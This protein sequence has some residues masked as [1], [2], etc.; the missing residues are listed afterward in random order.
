MNS[1]LKNY[2]TDIP[3]SR[4]IP[5]IQEILAKSG[6]RGIAFEYDGTGNVESIFFRLQIENGK[7]LTFKL[8]ANPKAV[9]QMMFGNLQETRGTQERYEAGR[10]Q[11]ALN[12]AWR[13]MKD[14]LLV[15]FSL[16]QLNQA[17]AIQVF[18]PYMMVGE[19]L[20]LYESMKK[21]QFIL[22]SGV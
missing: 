10:K 19:N 18:L 12:I 21:N 20:N 6:A 15:Q 2:T 17:E 8:P 22:S 11:R 9:Y 7:D 4:T 13:I 5:E 16:I 1:K 14:W 3:A